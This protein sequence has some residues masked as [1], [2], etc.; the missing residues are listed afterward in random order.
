M[1]TE[2]F[3]L[4]VQRREAEAARA[5]IFP[6]QTEVDE[7]PEHA[8]A[9]GN[10]WTRRLFDGD[11]YVS[12]PHGPRPS[13]SLVFVQSRDG[14]TGA[15]N[16]STLGGGAADKHL[17]YEGLSRVAADAV[18][19]GAQTIRGGKI[20]LSVWHPELVRLRTSLGLPRHPT[21]VIATLRGLPFD[22]SLILNVPEITVVLITIPSWI[23]LMA[24]ELE[25]RPWITAIAMETPHDLDG[26]LRQLRAM[27]I[28]RISCIGGRTLARQ[29][30]AAGLVDDLYL[31]T[32]AVNGGEPN[33]PLSPEPIAG[34]VI[35]R[36]HGTGPDA[37]VVV[38][39]IALRS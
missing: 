27:G 3:R 18:M 29:L 14:N 33:T 11:F 22:E 5:S 19:A 34:T 1:Q 2:D 17:I 26:A 16:P 13:T 39:Q 32:T 15:A 24:H 35:V 6:L 8:I 21:Q 38:E 9:I 37:G 20:V 28:A 12:A 10:T 4:F 25:R 31:T 36:K 7:R 23:A 30:L